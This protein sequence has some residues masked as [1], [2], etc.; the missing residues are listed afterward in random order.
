MLFRSS[1]PQAAS[2]AGLLLANAVFGLCALLPAEDFLAWGW[3]VPFLLCAVML[4][5]A[6]YI[7]VNIAETPEFR[8][9]ESRAE[10]TVKPRQCPD[11]QSQNPPVYQDR[12]KR[13]MLLRPVARCAIP[14][15]ISAPT[16]RA[17]SHPVSR[18]VNH[19]QPGMAQIP[20]KTL[21]FAYGRFKTI[22]PDPPGG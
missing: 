17:G 9:A 13:L 6:V 18:Q 12:P 10:R 19:A 16:N 14:M 5:V 15:A 1:L 4:A 22:C 2:P 21:T 20:G 3:R 11:R 7:R 8:R